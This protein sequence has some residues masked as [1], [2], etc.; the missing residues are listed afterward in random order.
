MLKF[1]TSGLAQPCS[2]DCKEG[3]PAAQPAHLDPSRNARPRMFSSLLPFRTGSQHAP[4]E[5][6]K[7]DHLDMSPG[8]TNMPP[9]LYTGLRYAAADFTEADDDDDESNVGVRRHLSR[10]DEIPVHDEDGVHEQ[11]SVLPL[12]SA[13]HLGTI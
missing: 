4:Q 7:D 11:T 2:G 1:D 5:R 13:T 8:L 9:S 12:F 3:S 6:L 10:L